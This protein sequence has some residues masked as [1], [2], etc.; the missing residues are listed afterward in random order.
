ML[1]PP[2]DVPPQISTYARGDS[3][4]RLF[5]EFTAADL[6]ALRVEGL[7][8][9][10]AHVVRHLKGVGAL[11][12]VVPGVGG[13][14]GTYVWNLYSLPPALRQAIRRRVDHYWPDVRLAGQATQLCSPEEWNLRLH[15]GPQLDALPPKQAVRADARLRIVDLFRRWRGI[16]GC[17][18]AEVFAQEWADGAFDIPEQVRAAIPSFCVKSLLT[19]ERLLRTQGPIALA[20]A[21]KPREATISATPELL[22]LAEAMIVQWPHLSGAD[23]NAAI[24][25]RASELGL[26]APSE[27]ACQRWLAD[28]K[29]KNKRDFAFLESPDAHKGKFRPAFGKADEQVTRLNQRWEFDAT[30]ADIMLADGL[31]YTI[32]AF[33]DVFS[34]RAMMRVHRTSSG[35][36]VAALLRA[37][38]IEYG[39]PEAVHTDNGSDFVSEHVQRV[40]AR[41]EIEH[42]RATVGA[43]EQKPFIERF[44]KTFSHGLLKLLGGYVGHDVA[45]RQKIESRKSFISRLFDRNSGARPI[46]ASLTAQELQAFCDN[47]CAGYHNRPHDGI[48]T[49]PALRALGWTGAV[50]RIDDVRALDVL[51]APLAGGNGMRTVTKKGIR[52]EN[53]LFIAPQLGDLVGETVECRQDPTDAGR[54]Y[55]FDGAREFVCIAED[56]ERTGISREEIAE[57]ARRQTK[58][59]RGLNIS[60]LK[61]KRRRVLPEPDQLV[62]D[63]VARRA[64]SSVIAFPRNSER[65]DT[66]AL[67]EAGRASRAEEAPVAPARTPADERRDAQLVALASRR[68]AEEARDP[69]A[70]RNARVARGL[71]AW[72]ALNSGAVIPEAERAWF[73]AYETTTEF[74]RALSQARGIDIR[75]GHYRSRATTHAASPNAS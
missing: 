14:A 26:R 58:T 73:E 34:R 50:R 62:R 30:K 71:A 61:D 6:L 17:Q 51:L 19:W 31:R 5:S 24:D 56:P 67:H 66:P 49:T 15:Q 69:R 41:L 37:G 70:E 8:A 10:A 21:Y 60:A 35:P 48:S 13:H 43:P 16:G 27:R 44:F 57:E 39:V 11:Y 9:R 36:A 28:W 40:L 53:G 20:G 4:Q 46:Q 68:R 75:R 47:W 63:I 18:R 29:R 45:S 54:I 59:L 1:T 74:L 52:V 25:L 33:I 2:P 3:G 23:L 55:V 65:H 12:T 22:D 64:A 42:W 38:L 72:D 7:P 32:V